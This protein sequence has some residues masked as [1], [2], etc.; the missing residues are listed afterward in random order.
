MSMRTLLFVLLLL[1]SLRL[2]AVEVLDSV[3]KPAVHKRELSKV[4]KTIRGFDRLNTEYIEPQHYNYTV[5]LQLTNTYENFILGSRNQSIWLAPDNRLKV[6]PYVGWR[7][8]FF[9]Y[10]FDLKNLGFDHGKLRKEFDLSIYSSQVGVDLFYRRT[11][12][13]YKLR[14]ARLGADI[15]VDALIGMPF[16]GISVGITGLNAYYIFNHGRFSYPAA[17]SQSTCQRASCGSWM[18][19]AGYARNTLDMDFDKLKDMVE[20]NAKSSSV[21]KLDSGLMFSDIDY[22]DIS[23]SGGYAYNWVFAKDWL[24]CASGQLA[25][26]YKTSHGK[27]KEEG[28]SFDFENVNLDGIGRFGLVYNNTRWYA[29]LSAIVHTN[30]Y[31]TDRFSANNVFG[32]MNAYMGFNFGLKKKYRN[33]SK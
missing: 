11:G 25:L 14:E 6:G 24:F 16:D 21:V 22:S 33:K 15:D 27:A 26:A 12:K 20:K 19:G 32:S 2:A 17:F 23:L 10:T 18:A 13:D 9:G 4:R 28:F 30:N 3:D 8:F 5:M 31:H 7:W 29:G 1:L